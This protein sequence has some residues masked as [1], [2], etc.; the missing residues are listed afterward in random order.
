MP[1]RTG[2]NKYIKG[3]LIMRRIFNARKF[4]IRRFRKRDE[5]SSKTKPLPKPAP[6]VTPVAEV[7]VVKEKAPK[8][9][10]K[11]TK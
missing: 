3:D 11:S 2:I 6:V 1:Q 4:N 8:L 10:A 7:P 9:R 5:L